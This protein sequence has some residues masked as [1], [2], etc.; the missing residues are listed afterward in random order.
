VVIGGSY[1]FTVQICLFICA[2]AQLPL[3]AVFPKL[4]E[5]AARGS[6]SEL[7]RL[8]FK[9]TVQMMGIFILLGILLVLWGQ[10][11]LTLIHAKAKLQAG[12]ALIGLIAFFFAENNRSNHMYIVGAFNRYPFWKYDLISAAA[13]LI[14]CGE[15]LHLG[16]TAGVVLWLWAVQLCWNFWWPIK[17]SLAELKM[18]WGEYWGALGGSF[19]E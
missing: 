6:L 15:A 9:K 4:N 3:T 7:K 12:A 18:T 13:I 14:G 17:R 1:G 5:L 19:S 8:F 2:I 11:C 10:G 16:G